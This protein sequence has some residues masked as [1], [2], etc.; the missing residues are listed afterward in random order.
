MTGFLFGVSAVLVL[1]QAAPLVGFTPDGTND[2][3]QFALVQVHAL[4]ERERVELLVVRRRRRDLPQHLV[5][6]DHVHAGRE[7]HV[8]WRGPIRSRGS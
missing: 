1:D 3:V 8:E 5:G 2:V 7:R 4:D 6:A